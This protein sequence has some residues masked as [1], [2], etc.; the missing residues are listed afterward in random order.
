MLNLKTVSLV[1]LA[2]MLAACNPSVDSKDVTK[3]VDC[4][5]L[6]QHERSP[7]NNCDITTDKSK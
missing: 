1:V 7:G 3:G 2:S 6:S 5:S 4:K